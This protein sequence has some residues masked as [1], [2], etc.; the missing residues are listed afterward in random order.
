MST[1]SIEVKAY[2]ENV[3]QNTVKVFLP[4]ILGNIVE[5]YDYTLYGF[6]AA[7][8]SSQFFPNDDPTVALIKTFGIFVAGSFSKPLG[9]LIF[10][11]IGDRYGRSVALK[12]SMIGIAFPTAL[13]GLMPSYESIGW[14]APML[15]L[16]C[17][18]LQGIFTAGESD[19]VRIFIYEF[20]GKHRPCFAT[21]LTTIAYM[22]GIYLASYISKLFLSEPMNDWIW[23]IPFL[24]GA[25]RWGYWC[26]CI[27]GIFA[28][29]QN[30]PSI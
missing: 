14:F 8:F 2:P 17:R 30:L 24:I 12:I 3:K 11:F 28:K 21:S 25:G 10:G 23:R 26:L 13:I 7:F 5:Y 27:D 18:I 19:G 1:A 4:A 20:V 29:R 16:V 9:A 6:C 22:I 15:L